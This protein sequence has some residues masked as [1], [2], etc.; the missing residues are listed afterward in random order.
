MV[1]WGS[2][3]SLQCQDA[4]LIPGPTQWVKGCGIVVWVT[5]VAQI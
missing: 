4:G 1:Q 3:V 2:A 5:T